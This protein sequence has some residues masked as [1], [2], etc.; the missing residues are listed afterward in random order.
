MNRFVQACPRVASRVPLPG[1]GPVLKALSVLGLV[2][3]SFVAGAAA[4]HFDLPPSGHLEKSFRGARAWLDRRDLPR[5]RS[6]PGDDSAGTAVTLDRP[7]KTCDGFTLVTTTL[8]TRAVLLDMRGNVV[9]QW[10]L[11]FRRAWPRPD[12]VPDPAPD[13][14]VHW[15]RCHLYPDGGLLAVYQADWH[16]PY[17]YGLARLD[18]DSNLLWAYPANVHH[19]VDVGEDGRIYTLT[20]WVV[21]DPPSGLD[22][23]PAPYVAD[24]LVVLSPDGAELEKVALVEAL[25]DSPY[26]L[27]LAPLRRAKRREPAPPGGPP[28]GRPAFLENGDA[29][30]ANSVRVLGGSLAA[31]FPL[32]APG[33]V[34][35]SLRNL[36]ALAVVDLPTRRVA[37]AARGLWRGQ[38][39][40]A[41]LDD[42]RLLLFDNLGGPA[43]ARV[44]EYDPVT[45]AVPWSYGGE[46]AAPFAAPLR[47]AAQRL[48]NGNTLLVDPDGGRLL[49]VTREKEPVWE[50]Y[51][52][53]SPGLPG[54]DYAP[55]SVTGARRYRAEDLTFLRGGARARP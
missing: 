8:D 39:D 26:A 55:A 10:Q 21:S 40:A 48:P 15:F 43:G 11:P 53:W 30:H 17:G 20:Q 41:F 42:G 49:E 47:G 3:L 33:Q 28:P 31:K 6:A 34:L 18:R 25:R 13:D 32:F 2:A 5:A 35:V 23:F 14:Q 7:G 44:L 19:D 36:D 1:P 29:L 38:H 50:C 16:T 51:G 52:P 24:Y 22:S 27:A 12:H 9:H 4:M 37:W 46:P 54:W 45:Q